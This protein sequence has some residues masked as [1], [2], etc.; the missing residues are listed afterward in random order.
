M[1][2][3]LW[4]QPLTNPSILVQRSA[5]FF[6]EKASHSKVSKEYLAMAP[7]VAAIKIDGSGRVH[8]LPP[9]HHPKEAKAE[10][11]LMCIGPA[12]L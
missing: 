10:R 6:R 7:Q 4:Q 5:H 8:Q 11:W 9:N 2:M 3:I 12:V 1:A